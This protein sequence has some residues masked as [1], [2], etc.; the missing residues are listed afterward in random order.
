MLLPNLSRASSAASSAFSMS[1]SRFAASDRKRETMLPAS[2]TMSAERESGRSGCA[3]E[4][5]PSSATASFVVVSS[6]SEF[7]GAEESVASAVSER[8]RFMREE[9]P[10]LAFSRAVGSCLDAFS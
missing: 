1:L 6:F 2:L 8:V 3:G 10:A 4:V 7:D 5:E 9:S